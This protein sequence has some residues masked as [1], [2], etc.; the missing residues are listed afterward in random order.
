MIN[1]RGILRSLLAAPFVITRPGLLMPIRSWSPEADRIEGMWRR[2]EPIIGERA[3]L[4]RGL[5]LRAAVGDRLM[6]NCYFV[7]LSLGSDEAMIDFSYSRETSI[8]DNCYFD[9]WPAGTKTGILLDAPTPATAQ[10]EGET[11]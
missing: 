7:F 4:E 1:R 9:A 6:R 11:Q 3:W 10:R 5:R 8:I 2:G